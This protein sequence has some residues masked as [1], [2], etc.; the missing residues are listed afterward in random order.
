M[1]GSS[2]EPRRRQPRAVS[3]SAALLA[4]AVL[5]ALAACS[6]RD[7]TAIA[8]R[9]GDLDALRI[10]QRNEPADLDPAFASMPDEFFIGRALSEGLVAPSP[11]G[12]GVVPAAA[13]SW[14][15][16]ADGLRYT[17]HL[18]AQGRWS[19]GDS[20]SAAQFVA[21]YKRILE[22][23]AP[24]PKA[25]LF[26]PVLNARAYKLGKIRD[27]SRVGFLA[28]DPRTLVVTLGG[29]CP[30]FLDYA[31]SGP[32]LP[33]N[34][35]IVASKGKAWT[36]PGNFVGNG[37]FTLEEW[38]P[39]QRIVVRRRTDY[40]DAAAIKVPA[41]EFIAMDNGEAEERSFRAGQLDVT[42]AVPESK[43]DAYV[44]AKP[45]LLRIAPLIETR[46]LAFNCTRH[47]LDDP[48]VRRALSM[49]LDRSELVVR[50]LKGGQIPSLSFLP[51]PLSQLGPVAVA[52][53]PEAARRA[54]ADAGYP[55]GRGFPELELTGWTNLPLLEAIQ[56]QWRRVLGIGVAISVRDAKEHISALRDGRYDIGLITLIPDVPD[57]LPSL[58]D[59]LPGAP[60]NYA[61]WSDISY[62]RDV[63]RARGSANPTERR[64]AI[65][66]AERR[67]LQACP[68]A[69]LYT[70][71][72]A[73]LKRAEV[74]GWRE[75]GLWN[76][77][78]KGV[79]LD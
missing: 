77:F 4:S 10:S 39:G 64:S 54:L 52:A 28:E 16:S 68:V 43:L 58:S 76:R 46:Y 73:Y 55:G 35:A 34:P 36:L 66:A 5:C 20:V 17:F 6:R 63:L 7:E 37:P 59:L 53:N 65:I 33:V 29:P 9:R 14:D 75:D 2:P 12:H 56:G 26:Y 27:F 69:P 32:W 18:R 67:L 19:N 40:W 24:A 70:N 41:I 38:T 71:T 79:R 47:P 44:A 61:H 62:S 13:S 49:A 15:V 48:R 21:S 42:M 22:P 11:D 45:T 1:C 3:A 57:P 78:Y 8:P 72:H 51:P 50:V 60:G 74:R 31:A 25:G 30:D 23:S